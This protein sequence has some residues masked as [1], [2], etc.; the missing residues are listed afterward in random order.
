[1]DNGDDEFGDSSFLDDFD[2]DAV[3]A[4]A[5]KH[6]T[7]AKRL[8]STDENNE[9]GDSSFLDDFDVDAAAATTTANPPA[10]KRP[11]VSPEG[12]QVQRH[13]HSITVEKEELEACVNRYYGYSTFKTGQLEAI[14]AV[15]RGEDVTVFWATG[16][17][18]S[19]CYQIPAL[20]SKKTAIVISPLI[21]LMQD[22]AQRLNGLS[23]K[24]LATYL[25]SAQLDGMEEERALRGDY[26]L[27]YITPEKLMTSGFLD[28]LAH[29]DLCCIAVDEAHCVSQWGHDFRKDYLYAGEKI[30]NHPQLRTVPII[31]LTA[32]AVP[33]IQEEIAKNLHLRSPHVNKQTFDRTNLAIK[34]TLK[35]KN[36]PLA[37]AMEP[38]IRS[39]T[40][41]EKRKGHAG[42]TIIYAA[43]RNSTEE[44]ASYLQQRLDAQGSTVDVKAYHAGMTTTTRHETH[45][46]FLTGK[47]AVVVATVAFGLGIDKPDTR[48]VIHWGPPKGVEEYY[49]QI[50]RAGRD[51]LPAECV[52]YASPSE[53]DRYMG[54]FYI[55]NLK[56]RAREAAI[57]STR[58]LKSFAMDKEGCRR[59]GLLDFFEEVPSFGERCGTCDN[60]LGAKK[61][62]DDSLRDF[63]NEARL[64]MSAVIALKDS[65]MGTIEKVL[66]GNIVENYRYAYNANP[67][68]LQRSMNEK[69][70]ALPRARASIQALKDIFATLSQKKF[71]MESTKSANVG[72]GNYSRSWTV[73]SVSD[74]GRRCLYGTDPIMLPVPDSLREVERQEQARREMVLKKL[75][76]KGVSLDTLPSEEL[77]MG[78]GEVI[79]AYSKWNNYVSLQEKLGKED[80]CAQLEELLSFVQEWRSNAAIQHT[81]A[82]ATVLPEH[83]MLSV[84][85][86]V[87]T[88]PSGVKVAK[89]DLIAAGART[90]ELDSLV[91][92]LN[93]WIDRYCTIKHPS[94]GNAESDET[95][96]LPMKFPHGGPV[97]V[98]KWD[99]A[100]YKPQKKTGKANWES[101]YERFQAGESPTAI[102]M[103]PANGRPIQVMTVVGHIL[104]GL[105]QGRPVDLHRLSNFS[106]LPSKNQWVELEQAEELTGMNAVGD[107]SCSGVGGKS[108]S[109]TDFLRPIMGE[110]FMEA[111]REERSEE[112][113]AKFGEWCNFLKWYLL[114]KRSGIEPIFGV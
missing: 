107:P 5:S 108:F 35:E 51:G 109:L 105:V 43:T 46:Q 66:K 31:A 70:N 24:T 102:S 12:Q 7:P 45:I 94:E 22:Q 13:K 69:R 82:P 71:L 61:Y 67:E 81:M 28:R 32:T 100:V 89:S 53:F 25:G 1:M 23:D 114:L 55:G 56:G 95:D 80:K 99:F 65:P 111:P 20:Y 60:C 75:E 68:A 40:R 73:Y 42:S 34:V 17:G 77:E 29:L 6:T 8:P 93:S 41:E 15:L 84:T 36:N 85:Y 54:E 90:R 2:V 11:K 86:A 83:I 92:I 104:E 91:D 106:Q 57:Q 10:N 72:G 76:E 33:R 37:S 79:R 98:R 48:R 26:R 58:A 52:M 27:V 21:S 64:I 47:T 113:R 78:D 3:V 103:A 14:Q 96:D 19:L 110:A 59:K 38:L 87:A 16:S 101:S 50:G 63:G 88:Y 62:G 74:T 44:V 39:L 18:K 9:F 49:Q 30:R 97:A 4:V 112:E